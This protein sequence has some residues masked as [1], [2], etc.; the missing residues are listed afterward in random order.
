[1]EQNK[2]IFFTIICNDKKYLED[3]INWYNRNYKTD[4]EI[5]DF[6]I[7]EVNFATVKVTHYEI[8]DIF[9]LGYQFGV[10]EQKLR[11]KGEIDW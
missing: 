3:T 10:K 1:M 6:K 11:Q 2:I 8:S 9:S 5:N 7:D 4:F